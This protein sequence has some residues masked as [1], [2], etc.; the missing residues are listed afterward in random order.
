MIRGS[1]PR[2]RQGGSSRVRR[3][4]ATLTTI[5]MSFPCVDMRGVGSNTPA[6]LTR[7]SNAGVVFGSV[8]ISSSPSSPVDE[9]DDC[10]DLNVDMT[11]YAMSAT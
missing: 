2:M 8:A 6:L 11:S 3:N 1:F 10:Q 9:E 7:Q 5:V 4:G